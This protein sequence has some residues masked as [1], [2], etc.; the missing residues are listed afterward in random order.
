MF[1]KGF[2]YNGIHGLYV[3]PAESHVNLRWIWANKPRYKNEKEA[4]FTW[5]FALR[6]SSAYVQEGSNWQYQMERM[7]K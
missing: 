6:I 4:Y 5:L 3:T 1:L 7:N 2:V